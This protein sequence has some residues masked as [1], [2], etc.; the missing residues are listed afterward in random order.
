MGLT[1]RKADAL[2]QLRSI[3]LHAAGASPAITASA[4]LI[5]MGIAPCSGELVDVLIGQNV[6]GSAGGTS[7]A[8]D[9]KK[10][11]TSM[12][13]TAGVLTRA[14]GDNKALDSR[15][16]LPALSGCTRPVIHGTKATRRVAKGDIITLTVTPTG[17]YSGSLPQPIAT[18]VINPD[19]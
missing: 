16:R 14:I 17:T 3:K 1:A 5:Q 9:V 4:V 2:S 13:A 19:L 11:A 18:I 10:G 15:G 12:L 6:A 8:F 7:L